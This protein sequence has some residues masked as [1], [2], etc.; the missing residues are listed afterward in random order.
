MTKDRYKATGIFCEKFLEKHFLK[1]M[2]AV[3]C[4]PV[5]LTPARL[6]SIVEARLGNRVC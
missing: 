2:P 3:L 4:M 1:K 6:R 5:I